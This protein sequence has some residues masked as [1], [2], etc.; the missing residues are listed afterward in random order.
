[1]KFLEKWFPWCLAVVWLLV[2]LVGGGLL[3]DGDYD[4]GRTLGVMT[5]LLFILL[6]IFIAIVQVNKK[7]S[8]DN[9][10][11]FSDIKSVMTE[12]TKYVLGVVLAIG[13]FYSVM[14]NEL[15]KKRLYDH[16][17]IEMAVDTPEKLEK[18]KAENPMLK[19]ISKEKIIESAT[20]RTDVFTSLK[21][22]IPSSLLV[23]LMVSLLYSLLAVAV[24]RGFLL[25]R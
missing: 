23:L 20:A 6:V 21:M 3:F 19:D 22:I 13:I 14:S 9:R 18:L 24:F 16:A 7:N 5:N 15:E 1:M 2:R 25:A 17:Q 12:S 4:K 11:F 8:T 10:T